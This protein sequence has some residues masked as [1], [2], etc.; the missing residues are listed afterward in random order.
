MV[1]LFPFE[2]AAGNDENSGCMKKVVGKFF[3]TRDIM[4]FYIYF[5]EEVKTLRG[6]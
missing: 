2:A 4:L 3:I 1:G 6:F 5:R